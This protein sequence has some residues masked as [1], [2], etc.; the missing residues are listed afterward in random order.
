MDYRYKAIV[1]RVYDGDTITVDIDLGFNIWWREVSLRLYGIDTPEIRGEERESGLL[2]RQ[3]VLDRLPIGCEVVIE[4]FKDK[5]E[6]YGRYLANVFYDG[7]KNLNLEL[8]QNNLAKKYE[9]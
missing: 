9:V 3:F 5:K 8:L 1:G 6:K 2:S 4:T 7:G